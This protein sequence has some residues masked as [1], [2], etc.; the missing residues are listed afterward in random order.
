MVM[1]KVLGSIV[2]DTTPAPGTRHSLSDNTIQDIRMC[3]GLI[4]ARERELADAAGAVMEKPY[5]VDEPRSEK[6]VSISS[7]KK[8]GKEETKE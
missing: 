8:S 1:R 3:L 5:F 7:I 4:T 2:R 6:V